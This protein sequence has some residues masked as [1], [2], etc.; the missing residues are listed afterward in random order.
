MFVWTGSGRACTTFCFDTPGGPVFAMNFDVF[1][2][3]D[4]LVFINHRGVAK[5]GFQPGTTGKVAKWVSKFGSVTFNV[6]GREFAVTGMNEAG[7]VVGG[8]EL[9]AQEYPEPDERPGVTIG[10]WVQYLLDTCAT[11]DE[12]VAMQSVVR[13]EDSAPPVHYLVSDATGK[14]ITVEWFDGEI[15]IRSGADASV[16]AMANMPYGRS[17]EALEIGGPRWWWSNPGQSAERVATAHARC[18]SYDPV[19]NPD[20][21]G[22]A[23]DTLKMVGAPHTKWSIVYDI[24]K[25]E[26]WYGSAQSPTGKHIVL[27]S[28]EMSCDSPLL[29]LDVNAK[30]EGEAASHFVPFDFD[31]NRRF[32]ETLLQRYGIEI[33]PED[34]LGIMQLFE[35]FDCADDTSEPVADGKTSS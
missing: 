3:G 13:I 28:F 12:A 5:E 7:L 1:I 17:A 4:G 8:M 16:R 20:A 18:T 21:I 30:F 19:K 22:Y 29:M 15:E 9:R 27:S 10:S 32:F 35:S 24:A 31:T 25:R 33:S 6:A 11:L 2:P 23:F 14:C 26:V 34:S